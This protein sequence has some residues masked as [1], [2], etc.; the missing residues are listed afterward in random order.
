M[1]D[2]GTDYAIRLIQLKD[3]E[4]EPCIECNRPVYWNEK[5]KDYVHADKPEIGC[6]LH[7]GFN[8]LYL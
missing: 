2:K 4:T 7:A 6:G 5:K 3:E 1:S 8:T